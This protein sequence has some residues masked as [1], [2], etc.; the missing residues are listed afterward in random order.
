MPMDPDEVYRSVSNALRKE[1]ELR[2]KLEKEVK[3]L[4]AEHDTLKDILVGRGIL[5]EG[6]RTVLVRIGDAAAARAGRTVKLNLYPD[7]YQV[8]NADVDCV[9]LFP[10]CRAR[11]CSFSHYLSVQDVQEGL[12][13]WDIEDPYHIRREAD[14]YC[15]HQSRK[16]GGCTIHPH[17]PGTC[18]AYDCRQDRRV[19]I[20]FEKKIPAPMPEGLV[21]HGE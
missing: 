7:K 9:A 13:K 14:G 5:I 6:H 3:A 2:D 1:L 10:L 19:W 20:D 12:V 16:T 11:C 8:A 17:R 15:T 21:P 4:R 18:R